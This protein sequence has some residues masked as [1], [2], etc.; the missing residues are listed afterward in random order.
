MDV[1]D[2]VRVL[3]R[4]WLLLLAGMLL[5]GAAAF[6]ASTLLPPQFTASTQLFVSTTGSDDIN[7]AVQGSYYAQSKVASYAELLRSRQ[8]ASDVLDDTGLDMATDELIDRIGVDV[9]PETTILDVTVTDGS[10]ERALTIARSIASE[11]RSLVRELETPDGESTSPVRITV[12][13]APERPESPS[14]PAVGANTALGAVLGLLLGAVIAVARD[15]LDT[16][17][18][19]D[20][21]ANAVAGAPVIGHLPVSPELSAGPPVAAASTSPAAEAVRHVRTN[22]AFLDVDRPPR[23]ILVSSSVAGEGKTTLAVN[24]AAALARAGNRVTLVDADLRRPRVTR[25]LRMVGGVGLTN[26]LTGTASVDE[27]AQT[28]DG[29]LRVLGAGPL[30]PNPSE[31]LASEAMSALVREVSATSDVVVIDAPPLLPV[32]DA[33]ALAG[34]VDGV[35]LCVRWGSVDATELQR[36][37]ALLQRLGARLLGLVM[38]QVP[39]RHATAAYG[40]GYLPDDASGGSPGR[41]RGWFRRRPKVTTVLAPTATVRPRATRPAVPAAT[42]GTPVADGDA[43]ADSGRR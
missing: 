27:V 17:V 32:A 39:A 40:Y 26:V 38:T 15:R 33:S 2:Y 12:T 30:P 13:A 16:T 19:D 25:A 24:L 31:L 21:V 8:L 35:L 41:L 14:S 3:R 9:V 36:S 29:G 20:T 1:R 28:V 34:L 10:P 37:S 4:G 7:I 42:T 23:R 5:G 43:F 11:F 18:K 22:L 6:G